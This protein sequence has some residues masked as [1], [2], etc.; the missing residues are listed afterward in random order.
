[1]TVCV[2]PMLNLYIIDLSTENQTT[3]S[4]EDLL[5]FITGADHVPPLGF[6]KDLTL[7]FYNQDV[8]MLSAR[9]PHTSTCAMELYLPR[10]I[11]CPS[12]LSDL[13]TR[14]INASL[15]FGDMDT[16]SYT[17]STNGQPTVKQE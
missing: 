6:S 10:S 16:N 12:A 4:F 2:Y 17:F 15:G 14:A 11:A 8:G 7:Q 9:L 5:A 3:F 13:L 1:M